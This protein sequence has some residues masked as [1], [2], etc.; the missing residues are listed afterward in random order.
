MKTGS[1]ARGHP[2]S[3]TTLQNWCPRHMALNNSIWLVTLV[4]AFLVYVIKFYARERAGTILSASFGL[5]LLCV[6]LLLSYVVTSALGMLVP[7]MATSFG[8]AGLVLF[9][10]GIVTF[11]G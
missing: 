8:I 3:R 7:Y 9:I 10:L 5:A 6:L 4:M 11:R 2:L 1:H